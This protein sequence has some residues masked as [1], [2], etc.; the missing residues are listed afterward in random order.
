MTYKPLPSELLFL[1]RRALNTLDPQKTPAWAIS[2]TDALEGEYAGRDVT[3]LL[4]EH[5]E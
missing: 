3:I 4:A 5:E 1:L 2:L